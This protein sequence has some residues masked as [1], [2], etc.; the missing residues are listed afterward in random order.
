M[1]SILVSFVAVRTLFVDEKSPEAHKICIKSQ[2]YHHTM[3]CIW[4]VSQSE[5]SNSGLAS[6]AT[7]LAREHPEG[8]HLLKIVAISPIY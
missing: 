6:H 4:L 2:S 3:T 8:K 7:G 5:N 1:I